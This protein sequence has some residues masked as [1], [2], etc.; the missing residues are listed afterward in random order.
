MAIIT[1]EPPKP[2]RYSMLSSLAPLKHVSL[3]K[4]AITM[5]SRS[6]R[7][8]DTLKYTEEDDENDAIDA[9]Q[10]YSYVSY[11]SDN[12]SAPPIQN[13]LDDENESSKK[14]DTKVIEKKIEERIERY[15]NDL[16]LSSSD[17]ESME[18]Y[19]LEFHGKTGRDSKEDIVDNV[20][21]KLKKNDNTNEV[22]EDNDNKM[23]KDDNKTEK[24]KKEDA[25][26]SQGQL[27]REKAA[28]EA[29]EIAAL[30]PSYVG[31]IHIKPV[32]NE[33]T[34]Q[35]MVDAEKDASKDADDS[36]INLKPQYVENVTIQ[37]NV[38]SINESMIKQPSH[39][40]YLSSKELAN[41]DENSDDEE[42]S[43]DKG[44]ERSD[45]DD[46]FYKTREGNYYE[47][48]IIL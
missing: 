48:L 28:R 14:V 11:D 44:K 8:F 31:Q 19:S 41:M 4:P 25:H 10:D 7:T 2:Q 32:V 9:Y 13:H 35:M 42:D 36:L 20:T 18:D 46:E 17:S 29:E 21:K 40:I 3:E 34:P 39:S 26:K 38:A 37:P 43:R 33:I 5:A 15:K 16:Y 22:E 12:D 47:F 24:E 27:E 1:N 45:S 6:S 23:E 30:K